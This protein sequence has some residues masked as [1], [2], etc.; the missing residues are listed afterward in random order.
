MHIFKVS[1]AISQVF[2]H[3]YNVNVGQEYVLLYRVFLCCCLIGNRPVGCHSDKRCPYRKICSYA[4][5]ESTHV[6][7]IMP[8]LW[9]EFRGSHLYVQTLNYTAISGFACIT[10]I[11][12]LGKKRQIQRRDEAVLSLS[13]YMS[14]GIRRI[15][16]NKGPI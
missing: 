5:G 12:I 13:T 1:R 10:L 14:C 16:D 15:L 3:A 6:C 4:K 8:V 2:S 11:S 7:E 9:S